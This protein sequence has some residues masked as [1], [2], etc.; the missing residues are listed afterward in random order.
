VPNAMNWF[1]F[2]NTGTSVVNPTTLG[3][4]PQGQLLNAMEIV[5]REEDTAA[6]LRRSLARGSYCS[7][8]VRQT[9]E[10]HDFQ[11]VDGWLDWTNKPAGTAD[12]PDPAIQKWS[13]PFLR[14]I[15]TPGW[16]GFDVPP[17]GPNT[18]QI[19]ANGILNRADATEIWVQQMFRTWVEGSRCFDSVWEAASSPVTWHNSLH[20]VRAS[21]TS[22]WTKG[23]N[24]R[25]E[26]GPMR[27][28]STA[29][30]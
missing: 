21:P 4:M 27:F 13:P 9:L 30:L 28:G 16:S 20:L 12:D 6:A 23:S 10:E 5:F 22:P 7:Y 11:F 25:I 1:Q 26:H 3:V 24:T 2:R 19:N 15:D 8:R 29:Q 14:S 17:V 18:R